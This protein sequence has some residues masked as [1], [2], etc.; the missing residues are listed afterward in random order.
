M[1]GFFVRGI[2]NYCCHYGRCFRDQLNILADD[3][4]TMK[5]TALNLGFCVV[6]FLFGE[7]YGALGYF[8]LYPA[9]D[10]VFHTLGGFLIANLFGHKKKLD[11]IAYTVL[12]AVLWEFFEF[13]RW[14]PQILCGYTD[15]MSDLMYGLSGAIAY[16]TIRYISFK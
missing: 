7:L 14:Y 8:D 15:T 10:A 6:L 9:S 2:R 13:V 4:D 5:R 12:I 11:I 1:E 16:I 3:T